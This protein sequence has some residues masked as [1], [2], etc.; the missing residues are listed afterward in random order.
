MKILN[1]TESAIF[2]SFLSSLLPENLRSD[3]FWFV[4]LTSHS[5]VS[6]LISLQRALNETSL[7]ASVAILAILAALF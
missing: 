3:L 6:H 4:F 5:R 1:K 7:G 2:V